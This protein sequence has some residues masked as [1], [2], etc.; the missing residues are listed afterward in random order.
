MVSTVDNPLTR[1]GHASESRTISK[2]SRV[3]I[4]QKWVFFQRIK[5]MKK[6]VL[7]PILAFMLALAIGACGSGPTGLTFVT[8]KVLS[9]ETT[10]GDGETPWKTV[11]FEATASEKFF[12][13]LWIGYRFPPGCSYVYDS[14]QETTVAHPWYA[15][16]HQRYPGK[17]LDLMVWNVSGDTAMATYEDPI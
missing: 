14:G 6:G 1:Q 10:G 17:Q 2:L 3:V 16:P 15:W 4:L 11:I 7:L 8:A 9:V 5:T 12:W 13:E